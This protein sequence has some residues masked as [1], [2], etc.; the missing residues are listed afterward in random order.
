[1]ASQKPSRSTFLVIGATVLTALGIGSYRLVVQGSANIQ[2]TASGTTLTAGGGRFQA[3]NLA[4]AACR[5]SLGGN[6]YSCFQEVAFTNTGSCVT[7][8][9]ATKAYTVATI[10]KPYT[11]SGGLER[12]VVN[13][14]AQ[15]VATNVFVDQ[16]TTASTTSG[17]GFFNRVAIS[18]GAI[19]TFSG[20]GGTLWRMNTPII[21][22][23]AAA[24]VGASHCVLQVNSFGSNLE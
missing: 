9:C 18:S 14:G 20:T 2:G 8:G 21:K 17:A 15:P 6:Y 13:C 22:V 10:T 24:R 4:D 23:T 3:T 12:I 7:S 5:K 1:M 16:S 11:G 19:K